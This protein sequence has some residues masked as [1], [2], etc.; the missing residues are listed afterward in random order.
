MHRHAALA[1]EADLSTAGQAWV[2][3]RLRQAVPWFCVCMCVCVCACG[4]GGGGWVRIHT[5][6]KTIPGT[7][8]ASVCTLMK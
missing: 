8:H 3:E 5:K 4:L 2:V 7:L 1:S 6:L